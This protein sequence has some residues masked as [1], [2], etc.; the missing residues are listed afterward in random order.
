MVFQQG[1]LQYIASKRGGYSS[2]LQGGASREGRRL[3]LCSVMQVIHFLVF[4]RDSMDPWFS[5]YFMLKNF[6]FQAKIDSYTFLLSAF[7][8]HYFTIAEVPDQSTF[9]HINCPLNDTFGQDTFLQIV[10]FMAIRT[11][12]HSFSAKASEAKKKV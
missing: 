1:R 9:C 10:S 4:I 12:C 6:T 3:V 7:F 11:K 8:L 5:Q 2:F